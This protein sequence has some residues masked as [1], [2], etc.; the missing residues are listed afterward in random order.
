VRVTEGL[1]ARDPSPAQDG[2]S[3]LFVQSRL[4]KTRI[5]SLALP[6]GLRGPAREDDIEW[7]TEESE[8]QYETP[9][10]SPD[11]TM[12]VA[13]VWQPGGYKD[14]WVL[15]ARGNRIE[16]LMHDRAVDG[17][18]A[19]SPD[20]KFVYFASDRTGIF[21]LFAFELSTKKIFQVTNVLGGAFS[22]APSPDGATLAFSS[23][24]AWGYDLHLLGADPASWTDAGPYEDPYPTVTYA[25]RQVET[26]AG[27]Y[28]PLPTLVPR[29]WLPWYGFSEASRD[30]FGFLT[31]GQDAV[32]RHAYFLSGLYSP[33]THR[34]WYTFNYSYD[35]LYPT[36]LLAASDTDKTFS[37]LLSLPT[38]TGDYTEREKTLD[39]SLVFPL[40]RLENQHSLVV[41][42]RRREISALTR[43][44]AGY[45]GVVP[46]EG[47][48]ASGRASYFFNSANSYRN[49]ISPEDGRTIELGYE[50]IDKTLGSDFTIRKYT[51]DWHEYLNAPWKHHVLLARGFAGTSSGDVIPQR[52]FQLGGDNPGDITIN[53]GEEA[54]FLRGYPSNEF[55]G[56][57]AA[58]A[59]LEYRFPVRDIESGISG[60]APLFFRRLHGA[61]F[62]EAGNAWDDAFRARDFKKAVGAEARF[63]VYFAYYV[64]LTFRI[65]FA[66]GLDEKRETFLIFG[67]WAPALF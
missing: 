25:D 56:R 41:G 49:S 7:L 16:E 66:K 23:Y 59:S 12:I 61:L 15:D 57:N 62:A 42:Y 18:G 8:N 19:W 52:A 34:K 63:D 5:G 55:R 26:K 13:G 50:Q 36:V 33:Q 28:D 30:L 14:I 10:Y 43:L 32:E 64:P 54:V 11:G 6:A 38:G 45:T 2:A 9:Q 53:V 21:N 51:A 37:D 22:P 67:L 47:L 1:R 27:S 46:A 24:S 40:L 20:G 4:G 17:G 48:L 65:G 35:G 29:F 39:A 58:L 3:L 60:N 31:F 44:P